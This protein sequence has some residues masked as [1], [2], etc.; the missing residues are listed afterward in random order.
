MRTVWKVNLQ[1][2]DLLTLVDPKPLRVARDPLGYLAMWIE[3]TVPD[4]GSA[5]APDGSVRHAI[6]QVATGAAIPL[7]DDSVYVDT[8][9]LGRLVVHFY[10]VTIHVT[11]D[12]EVK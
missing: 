7:Y 10:L 4:D 11:E 5:P 1:H 3:H 6:T 12:E 9:V 8:L 2:T